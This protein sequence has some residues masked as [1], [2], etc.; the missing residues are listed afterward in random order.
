MRRDASRAAQPRR[1]GVSGARPCTCL[2]VVRGGTTTIATSLARWQTR[3]LWRSSLTPLTAKHARERDAERCDGGVSGEAARASRRAGARCARCRARRASKRARRERRRARACASSIT[4]ST[5]TLCRRVPRPSSRIHGVVRSDLG[6]ERDAVG[7][8]N[9]YERAELEHALERARTGF[10]L[11]SSRR[12]GA[13]SRRISDSMAAV[14]PAV[15]RPYG[16]RTT[17]GREPIRQRCLGLIR[18]LNLDHVLGL[19]RW[20]G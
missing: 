18:K 19:A 7:R 2:D 11:S 16:I 9:E 20:L 13:R 15:A 17:P 3:R 4:A 8:R 14:P 12:R 6:D 5:A 10:V 1:G